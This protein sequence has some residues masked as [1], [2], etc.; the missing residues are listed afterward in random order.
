MGREQ[1]VATD[2]SRPIPAGRDW[3]LY[4]D[5]YNRMKCGNVP[6]GDYQLIIESY[7]FLFDNGRSPAEKVKFLDC[8][9]LSIDE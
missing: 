1:T 9:I 7:R 2:S 4:G 6:F 5:E 3:P 8:S